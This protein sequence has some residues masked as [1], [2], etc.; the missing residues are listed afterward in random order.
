MCS[1][2]VD[3]EQ[4]QFLPSSS[5]M[6]GPNPEQEENN[7]SEFP[8][9]MDVSQMD[10]QTIKAASDTMKVEKDQENYSRYMNN[11]NIFFY[12]FICRKIPKFSFANQTY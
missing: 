8:P 5:A 9:D 4:Q 6:A 11:I 7:V 2:V 10:F 12:S 3:M 1:N